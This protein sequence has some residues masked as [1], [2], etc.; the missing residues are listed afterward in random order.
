MIK[1]LLIANRG[2]IAV[3]IIRTCREMG[4]KSV[5]VYSEAD[6][7]ALHVKMAD[8]AVCIGPAKSAESYLNKEN[9]ISA[10]A[11]THCDAIHPGVGF[12]SENADFADMVQKAGLIWV[13]ARPETI[14]L[15]GDKVQAK[16]TALKAGMPVIPGSDGAVDADEALKASK[17]V[18]F[19]VIVKAASGGGGKGMRIVEKAE[20]LPEIIKIASAEALNCFSDGRLYLERYI[21]NPRHVEVQLLGDGNGKAL[22]L[23]ERDCS[24]QKNHQ[25]LL[26]ESPS[27]A[28][29]D[30]MRQRMQ[31][32]SVRLFENLKYSGAGTIEFLVENGEYYFME[33]NARVQV[34]HTVTE[35][36]TGIDIIE[37]QIKACCCGELDYN[38][39]DINIKGYCLETRINAITPGKIPLFEA[40]LGPFVRTDTFL[41][42]GCE[43]SPFYDSMVAKILVYS[44]DR[45]SGLKRM[46]RALEELRI[47]GIKTN[48]ATQEFIIRSKQF[49]SGR[50]GTDLYAKIVKE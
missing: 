25:K 37:Q 50:F 35:M 34:E 28:V 3:R 31:A 9:L 48:V 38:Q 14:N 6:R 1:T 40:P 36:I 22:Y 47:E 21:Q 29:S 43:V 16:E 27:T 33:V 20:D 19:P 17:K 42:S 30:E 46:L 41:Y 49:Q 13:G 44:K 32:D 15:L 11:L 23:G 24:V 39:K 4:I 7:N 2:E 26:E 45:Q 8:K 5:A 12:L 18:G 10:A